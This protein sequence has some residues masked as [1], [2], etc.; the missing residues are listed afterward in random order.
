MA[1]DRHASF[2]ARG[3]THG[4]EAWFENTIA[5][6]PMVGRQFDRLRALAASE[7]PVLITGEDGSGREVVA[8]AIHN[9]SRRAAHPF[10][11]IDCASLAE[12]LIEAE[13]FGV[14]GGGAQPKMGIFEQAGEGTVLLAE[15]GE[16]SQ[17]LQER[18]LRVLDRHELVRVNGETPVGVQAR[19]LASTSVDLRSRIEAAL[20]SD[21]LHSRLASEV[22]PLPP[23]R[24]RSEDIPVLARTF[25]DQCCRH[26]PNGAHEMTDEAEGALRA[27]HWPGNVRE[28]REVVE[29]G[30]LRA[31]GSRLNVEHLP[32]RLRGTPS[33]DPLA[34]L[35]DVEMRHI[36]RVLHEAHGN[37]RRAS[38]I[39]GISRW[40]LSRRLR[41]YG[42]QARDD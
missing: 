4:P 30:V 27:Y 19:I 12:P 36:E 29:D 20:F 10:V 37:Q 11:V 13:L 31:H 3:E 7:A 42:M 38:R 32:E 26:L 6:D 22:L 18:L 33:G 28:L 40:S 25:L 41:K 1:A 14:E 15:V 9:L 24:E 17:R 16:L 34:S 39:L 35:R 2:A 5:H 23:L 8:R 21:A